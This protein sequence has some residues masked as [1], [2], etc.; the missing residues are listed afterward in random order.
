MKYLLL[1]GATGLLGAYLIRDAHRLDL[2]L[3][4]VVRSSRTTGTA[5][6]RIENQLVRWERECGHA[7][8]RPVVLEGDLTAP[9]LGLTA[10]QQNWLGENCSAVLHNA[11]SLTFVAQDSESEPYRS[12]VEGVRS[13]LDLCQAT[14]IRTFHHVST[15]YVCGLREGRVFEHELD[16][17]QELGN[18][19]ERSKVA[20]EKLVRS[21]EHLRQVT[22][23]RPAI[24]TGDSTNGYTSTFHGLYVP[25]KAACGL[26]QAISDGESVELEP[27]LEA[28]ALNGSEQKNF[29]PVDW[30]SA[31]IMHIVSQPRLHGRTYHLTPRQ[32]TPVGLLA[33]VIQESL[34]QSLAQQRKATAATASGNSLGLDGF[35]RDLMEQMDVY[36]SYWRDDPE[37]DS[38]N[39]TWAAPHLPCPVMDR[40]LLKRMCDYA[41]R[42]NFGWPIPPPSVPK[43]DTERHFV[44]EDVLPDN[45]P[46]VEDSS[47]R[48]TVTAPWTEDSPGDSSQVWGLVVSGPGG[49]DWCL[50][51]LPTGAIRSTPGLSSDCDV[52][53]H[54]HVDLLAELLSGETSVH[55]AALVG[56]ILWESESPLD[57]ASFASSLE[58]LLHTVRMANSH[59]PPCNESPKPDFVG[60]SRN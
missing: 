7:L 1:T 40:A 34:L 48:W 2:P 26:V 58:S 24:I 60:R 3:A 30:V 25:L 11:A 52:V 39:T 10:E 17:G 19:Y 42:S 43:W 31:V 55:D 50:R 9:R 23:F 36:R 21:A 59:G 16:V 14:G 47:R 27:L 57:L 45:V 8:R 15:A 44:G 46:R 6:Q 18:D 13:V 33:E 29:V 56:K 37:F 28:F 20:A 22:V 51:S 54:L 53:V 35:S 4:V 41:I 5:R 12:N 32:R 49:G 38:A